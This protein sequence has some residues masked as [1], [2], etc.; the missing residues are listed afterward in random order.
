MNT[1]EHLIENGWCVVPLL[2]EF[3][4]EHYLIKIQNELTQIFGTENFYENCP[5]VLDGMIKT[6]HTSM[7]R[8][9]HELRFHARSKI[10]EFLD[11][12]TWSHFRDLKPLT[13]IFQNLRHENELTCNPDAIFVSSG[14]S[15]NLAEPW[16]HV[17]TGSISLNNLQG[18]I[19]LAN[20][21]NCEKMYVLQK[22]HKFFEHLNIPQQN[23][24]AKFHLLTKNE[25]ELLKTLGCEPV[26][27]N[28]YTPPGSLVLWFSSTV[29]HVTPN[30]GSETPRVITYVC[31]GK[32]DL[33]SEEDKILK[34]FAVL[35]GGSCR[36]F[37]QSCEVS[38]QYGKTGLSRDLIHFRE[39]N[40][41]YWFLFG[42]RIHD[43]TDSNLNIY[44]LTKEDVKNAIKTIEY[45]DW[46]TWDIL[47]SYLIHCE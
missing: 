16:W 29:H 9:V 23:V 20:P 41:K 42:S 45:D 43:Y 47:T 24:Q 4:S 15:N 35:F 26:C 32:T 5:R 12:K 25:V 30:Q 37:P 13:T 31:F 46:A 7:L 21:P 18:S 44:G 6:H 3:L 28:D 14:S 19:V 34:T 40:E 22:S 38:W 33:L 27:V 2:N 11:P 1:R 8:S 36:H 10:F 17:D 39:M